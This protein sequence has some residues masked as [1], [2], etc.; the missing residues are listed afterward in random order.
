MMLDWSG[1]A[2]LRGGKGWEVEGGWRERRCVRK[3]GCVSKAEKEKRETKPHGRGVRS[4]P[5]PVVR[6][7]GRRPL[8]RQGAFS[9]VAFFVN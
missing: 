9:V 5:L 8:R 4:D 3:R 2:R 6:A 1:V 7:S